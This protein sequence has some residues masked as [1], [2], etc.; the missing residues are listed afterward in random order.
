MWFEPRTLSHDTRSVD[1]FAGAAGIER[2]R[3]MDLNAAG[4][5]S[6]MNVGTRR[7]IG[8]DHDALRHQSD[9]HCS[10]HGFLARA[11]RSRTFWDPEL[12]ADRTFGA[13]AQGCGTPVFL[14]LVADAD[15]SL[16]DG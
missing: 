8:F 10:G 1:V 4:H 5:G 16:V 2:L 3:K 11:V 13:A 12:M 6:G 15:A 7:S 14:Q 9:A